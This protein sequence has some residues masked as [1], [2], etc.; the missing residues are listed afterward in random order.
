[1]RSGFVGTQNNFIGGISKIGNTYFLGDY[2]PAT[3]GLYSSDNGASWTKVL[4]GSESRYKFYNP[5][6]KIGSQ[7]YLF[8]PTSTTYYYSGDNGAE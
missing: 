7:T 1:M 6:V 2:N 3:Q 8:P 4:G 5:P